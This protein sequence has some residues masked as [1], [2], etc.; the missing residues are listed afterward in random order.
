[1]SDQP[2]KP[3]LKLARLQL[4]LETLTELTEQEADLVHGGAGGVDIRARK[5][6]RPPSKTFSAGCTT[7]F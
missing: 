1:M 2:R 5:K 7:D 3:D 4:N 6:L